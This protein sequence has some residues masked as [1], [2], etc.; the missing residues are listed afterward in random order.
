MRG[1]WLPAMRGFWL[2]AALLGFLIGP[3]PA[4]AEIREDGVLGEDRRSAGEASDRVVSGPGWYVWDE[5]PDEARRWGAAQPRD[6][7]RLSSRARKAAAGAAIAAAAPPRP[8][9]AAT[10]SGGGALLA[11][12][13]QSVL[14]AFFGAC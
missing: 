9:R 4:T 11:H 8:P 10:G 1:F 3:A 14:I 6:A 5:E 2:P 13:K 12:T 7:S